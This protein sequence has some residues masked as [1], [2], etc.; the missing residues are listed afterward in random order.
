MT[1]MTVNNSPIISLSFLVALSLV[2]LIGDQGCGKNSNNRSETQM[3]QQ[4]SAQARGSISE[5]VWGGEHVRLEVSGKGATLEFDCAHGQI[6]EPLIL[7]RA[8]RFQ[9]KGTYT[10]E[11]GGPVR[12]TENAPA[13]P[14]RY[15][16]SIKDKKMTLSITLTSS[17]ESLGA[18]TLVQGSEGH[19]VKCG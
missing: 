10:Q 7:D 9:A 3:N 18:F 19:V 1:G 5:G 6:L 15:S 16:G 12:E 17:S 11:H 14:V 4:N 8:G 2:F 13:Q